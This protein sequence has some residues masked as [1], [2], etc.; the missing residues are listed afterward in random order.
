MRPLWKPSPSV[1]AEVVDALL[2]VPY[3]MICFRGPSE[4]VLE[5]LSRRASPDLELLTLEFANALFKHLYMQVREFISFPPNGTRTRHQLH[6][7]NLQFR[8]II[9]EAY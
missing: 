2:L 4:N 1:L 6:M 8:G 5:Y 3:A 7:N 9:Y